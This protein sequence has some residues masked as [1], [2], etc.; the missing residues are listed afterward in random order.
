MSFD[1][2]IGAATGLSADF[3]FAVVA[4][5]LIFVTSCASTTN[6]FSEPD[7]PSI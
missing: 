5:D 7:A 4:P 1:I 2:I 6:E 3:R